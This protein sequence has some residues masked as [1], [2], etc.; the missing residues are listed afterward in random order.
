M[1]KELQ[2]KVARKKMHNSRLTSIGQPWDLRKR[3][4]YHQR[5]HSWTN[6]YE[7]WIYIRCVSLYDR[8]FD[9]SWNDVVCIHGYELL[10][11]LW[12]CGGLRHNNCRPTYPTTYSWA[13]TGHPSNY[14]VAD[15]S[16]WLP[17]WR[18]LLIASKC[19]VARMMRLSNNQHRYIELASQ[20]Q[21]IHD[22]HG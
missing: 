5:D 16:P 6:L 4:I 11:H 8:P 19:S 17:W 14:Y 18:I 9:T 20:E 22:W 10:T 12:S 13:R 15:T 1:H 3:T 2:T 21:S 7:E